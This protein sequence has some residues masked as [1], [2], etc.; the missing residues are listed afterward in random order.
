[1]EG[2]I[3]RAL[4]DLAD[5]L[6]QLGIERAQEGAAEPREQ[7]PSSPG[8]ST[9]GTWSVVSGRS[10]QSSKSEGPKA[11]TSRPGP[12]YSSSEVPRSSTIAYHSERRAYIIVS[13]P[14]DPSFVGFVEGPSP[15]T[16]RS[17]EKRLPNERL[18]GS[19]VKLRRV[20]DRNEALSV[21]EKA[22]PH[23]PMPELKI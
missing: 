15:Q 10:G 11:S 18:S 8:G 13:N 22:W 23:R 21:W 4:R 16:W 2:R 5:S 7:L 19:R 6:E 9:R 14:H 1:M 12:T 3:S 20:A 17:I